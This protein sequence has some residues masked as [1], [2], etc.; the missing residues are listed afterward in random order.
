MATRPAIFKRR[1]AE[2][3]IILCAGRWL[4]PRRATTLPIIQGSRT[5]RRNKA[6]TFSA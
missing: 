1:Q 4:A 2:P 3:V 6:R 5:A